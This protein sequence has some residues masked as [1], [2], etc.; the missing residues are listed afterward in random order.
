MK[1]LVR[2]KKRKRELLLQKMYVIWQF[3][4]T[5]PYQ[6]DIVRSVWLTISSA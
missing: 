2:K 4:Q 5:V 6:R 1:R 3:L